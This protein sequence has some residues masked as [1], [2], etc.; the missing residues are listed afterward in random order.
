MEKV[1][2]FGVNIFNIDF[3][4][5]IEIIRGFLKED[6]IHAIVTPNTEIA[7][8]ARDNSEL[9]DIINEQELVIPDGIGLIYGSKL[10]G[11]PLKERVT[12]YDVSIKLLDI[13]EEEGYSLY[14]LGTKPET[15][16]KAYEN[17]KANR[18]KLNLVGY[19]NGYF[20]GAHLGLAGHEEEIEVLNDINAKKPDIIFLGLGYPKQELW[21]KANKDKLDSKLII[22]NGGVIDI[23]A[24]EVKRAP[25][26]FIKL[27]L[28]WFYRLISDPSRIKR[29]LAIPKFLLKVLTDK[30]AVKWGGF[31]LSIETRSI[32]AIRTLSIDQI[33]KANSGHPGLPL[34]AAPMGYSVFK[35][36][37]HNPE[38]KKW[39]NRDRFIL[40]AGHG[41]AM[42]YSL[43]HLYGYGLEIEDLKNFRQMGS[44]TPGHPEYKHT[45]GVEATTGP[46]GQGISMAVG[47]AMA[48]KHLAAIYNKD[49]EIIDHN[50]FVICGDGDLMEGISNEASSL[51]GT[52]E[53]GKLIVLYDS[54]SITIE[55][56]TDLAFRENV[57][58][59]YEAMGWQTLLV[60]D[61]NDYEA[62]LEAIEKAKLDTKRP[63]LIEVVT[64]IGYGSP[65]AG[66]AKAHGEPLGAEGILE[67]KKFLEES[68]EDFYVSEE[69]Y[70]HYKDIK[71]DLEIK[72]ESDKRI[73]KIYAEKYPEEYD[74]LIKSFNGEFD[75]DVLKEEDFYKFE[76][77]L[78][79]RASSGEALN[80][81]ADKF[82]LLFGGSAD[83]GPSNKSVMNNSKYFSAETPEGNNL[84]FGIREHAMA[85]AVNGIMLHG[86]LKG[87]AATFMVFSDYMK[88]AIR[89]SALQQLP[90]IYV[91]THDSI[92]VGED[93]PTHQPIEHLAMLRSIP[94]NVV[95]RPADA[96][97]AA[98][99]WAVALTSKSTPTCLV[100]SRQTLPNL[101]SSVEGAQ[102][103]AYIIKKEEEELETIVIATGSEVSKAI[104]AAKD[105]KNVRVVSMP[106][107]ALF[108]AQSSEYR[109]SI[110]PSTIEK[111]IVVEAA[112][113]F[114]WH[115][116]TGLKGKIISIDEFGASGP[117]ESVFEY[118]GI[119]TENIKKTI[120]E[121]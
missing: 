31:K 5:A 106:S 101:N 71:K 121:F 75:L 10:R 29:Q 86:G 115:K 102:K 67:T 80:R 107:R 110:I 70:S 34:G 62:I 63:T 116:Y 95:F 25:D 41:S 68:E 18:P 40:S 26:I 35:A 13:C 33:Q 85:A 39:F 6:K 117:G 69:V 23:L 46:L 27:N 4:E 19:H 82:D 59:R 21:I 50:T 64:E 55:G 98:A 48:E 112:S 42:L 11:K 65:R 92:G 109:E 66:L 17:L 103:G 3:N 100:L 74:K 61:G 118:F 9:R 47:M 36:M 81:V 119:T 56:S 24:G 54:N 15:V 45:D 89:L 49:I 120:E 79:S 72:Y 32:N 113:S 91:L 38:D 73:E 76:K 8:D 90:A 51:A 88:P 12:G 83:L 22:G 14:L 16:K 96:R 44:K 28:E 30:D 99:G 52:L 87:Y 58:M 77:D 7:I 2:I 111:R 53:L 105:Y 20:K 94:N 93:G 57:R 114:G 60:E 104:E 78:A 37:K 1:S 108:E 43:L 84:D 97:E